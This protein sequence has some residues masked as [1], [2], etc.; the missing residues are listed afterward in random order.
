MK[1]MLL[2]SRHDAGGDIVVSDI[3]HMSHWWP[4]WWRQE[5]HQP[6]LLLCFWKTLNLHVSKSSTSN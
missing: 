4:H 5:R 3:T 1:V 2:C 6:A